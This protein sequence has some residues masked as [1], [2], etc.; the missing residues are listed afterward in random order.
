[1]IVGIVDEDGLISGEWSCKDAPVM[2]LKFTK[3]WALEDFWWLRAA[4]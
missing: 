2:L 4:E 3:R 1:M